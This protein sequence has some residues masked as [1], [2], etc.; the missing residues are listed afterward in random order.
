MVA[1]ALHLHDSVQ[2][3]FGTWFHCGCLQ[4]E[5]Q[6]HGDDQCELGHCVLILG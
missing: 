6:Q 3:L 1:L 2:V 4:E 5:Q